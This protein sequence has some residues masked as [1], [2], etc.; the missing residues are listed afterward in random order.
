[1]PHCRN[2][3]HNLYEVRSVI[4]VKRIH[5]CIMIKQNVHVCIY[6]KKNVCIYGRTYTI[7][8][9]DFN[10]S[11]ASGMRLFL[12]FLWYS[13]RR[14]SLYFTFYSKDSTNQVSKARSFSF[15]LHHPWLLPLFICSFLPLFIWLPFKR[16]KISMSH[17]SIYTHIIIYIYI[18][19]YKVWKHSVL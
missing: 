15:T 10:D 8:L 3:H 13:F 1:M 12:F 19:T 7:E 5:T 14:H 9:F 16:I 6:E 17:V 2:D 18:Y 4:F 11:F